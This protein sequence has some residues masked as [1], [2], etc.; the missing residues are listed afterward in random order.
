MGIL[1]DRFRHQEWLIGIGGVALSILVLSFN[2]GASFV[3]LVTLMGIFSATI[4]AP[5]YSLP[6][7]LLKSEHLGLGFGVISTCSSVGLFVAPYLVGKAKDV[8]GSDGFGFAMISMFFLLTVVS[9]FF[10]H[11]RTRQFGVRS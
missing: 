4:P 7:E 3:L 2:F 8:T 11:R 6:P 1:V 9:I 5:I 10:V